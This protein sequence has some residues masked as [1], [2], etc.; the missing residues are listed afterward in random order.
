MK[1]DRRM[2]HLIA[3]GASV[4]ANCQ[5]CL[6]INIDKA[7]ECGADESE[8][9]DA[10]EVG[11]MVREGAASKMD[12]FIAGFTPQIPSGLEPDSK[13]CACVQQKVSSS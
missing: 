5:P 4:S 7:R 8:L 13:S 12:A 10:V 2:L 11:K 9:A 1:L 6:Q 3:V